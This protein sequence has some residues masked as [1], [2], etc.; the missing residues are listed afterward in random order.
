MLVIQLNKKGFTH[1]D[2][3]DDMIEDLSKH[4]ESNTAME[5]LEYVENEM[6]P[7]IH[8]S[9]HREQNSNCREI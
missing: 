2:L 6:L 5:S 1:S 8:F 9:S 3:T 7:F 4:M